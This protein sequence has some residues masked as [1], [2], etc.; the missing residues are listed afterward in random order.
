MNNPS[1]FGPGQPVQS[2]AIFKMETF[3]H[4]ADFNHVKKD[5]EIFMNL[6]GQRQITQMTTYVTVT[7]DEKGASIENWYTIIFYIF[8]V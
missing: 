1:S 7:T 5:L 4:G 2:R 8:M 6:P 3:Q